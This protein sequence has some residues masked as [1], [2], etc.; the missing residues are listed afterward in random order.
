MDRL[1]DRYI[2]VI[3]TIPLSSAA[4]AA[5]LPS[6]TQ[7]KGWSTLLPYC[8]D[9]FF[10]PLPLPVA[11]VET[12]V[13]RRPDGDLENGQDRQALTNR[14]SGATGPRGYSLQN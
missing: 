8:Q 10:L 13:R 6:T 4:A 5:A 3:L 7:P 11:T 9:T 2:D 12:H 1:S 14:E